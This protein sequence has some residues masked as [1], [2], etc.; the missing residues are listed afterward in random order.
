VRVECRD[1]GLP[2]GVYANVIIY[3]IFP[4]LDNKIP[5]MIMVSMAVIDGSFIDEADLSVGHF[6]LI[7]KLNGIK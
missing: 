3:L 1:N 5:N 4:I 7:E 2:T 6:Y